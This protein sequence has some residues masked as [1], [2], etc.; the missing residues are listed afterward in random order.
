M[1]C[2]AEP[3][4]TQ[5]NKTKK[6]S[7]YEVNNRN[8]AFLGQEQLLAEKFKPKPNLET[9]FAPNA[10]L[11]L[12][13]FRDVMGIIKGLSQPTSDDITVMIVST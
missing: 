12:D 11:F 6:I 13:I 7:C 9:S 3:T 4:G 5:H 8:M 2:V 10:C 1:S